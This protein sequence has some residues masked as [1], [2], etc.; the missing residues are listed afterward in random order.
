MISL[1]WGVVIGCLSA[2]CGNIFVI[3]EAA[4]VLDG[5]DAAG[6]HP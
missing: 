5:V 2:G 4:G 6:R 3:G 1:N